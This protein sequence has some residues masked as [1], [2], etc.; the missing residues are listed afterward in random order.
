L[1][2]RRNSDRKTLLAGLTG[3]LLH[4]LDQLR[5][6]RAHRRREQAARRAE[7]I[8]LGTADASDGR[9]PARFLVRLPHAQILFPSRIDRYILRRFLEVGLVVLGAAVT[10]YIVVDLTE[11][12]RFVL[13][14]HI[15][16][17][18]VIEHYQYYSL[19]IIYTIAPIVVL[20]TTLIT[21][22]L[23]SRTSE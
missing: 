2:A 17:D 3:W 1:L 15:K 22:G 13:E 9:R 16:A 23:L 5:R 18:L 12:A 10:L 14:N 19:Q 11:L 7:R 6:A 20:L 4:P 8:Q 21:F